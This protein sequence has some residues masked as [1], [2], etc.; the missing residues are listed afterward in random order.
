MLI[1]TSPNVYNEIAINMPTLIQNSIVF[2]LCATVEWG[3]PLNL[4]PPNNF[5]PDTVDMWVY[6][7]M[8]N[9]DAFFLE[10]F[11]VARPLSNGKN[12]FIL[13]YKDEGVYDT[14]V[15]GICKV[16][17]MRYGFIAQTPNS[18]EDLNILQEFGLSYQGSVNYDYDYARYI[19]ILQNVYPDLLVQA[20]QKE[21]EDNDQITTIRKE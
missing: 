1:I 13:V 20:L 3:E 10:M 15:E 7:M 4:L 16:F 17:Q 2:N 8:A 9:N 18:F 12:I 14:L 11:K 6:D 19:N 5:N 21:N